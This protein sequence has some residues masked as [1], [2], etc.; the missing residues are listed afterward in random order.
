ML[1]D[2]YLYLPNPKN[3][4]PTPI[5][6]VMASYHPRYTEQASYCLIDPQFPPIQVRHIWEF[7]YPIDVE[8]KLFKKSVSLTQQ[9]REKTTSSGWKASAKVSFSAF[10]SGV[11]YSTDDK[12]RN[13][14][15]QERTVT[16]ADTVIIK[17]RTCGS[18]R[19]TTTV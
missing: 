14:D 12:T 2:S 8:M 18:R 5:N 7:A 6:Y 9:L 11:E 13:L 4:D 1:S 10:E 15:K 3:Q 17:P 16:E 19:I